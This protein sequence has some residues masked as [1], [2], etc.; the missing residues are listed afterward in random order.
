MDRLRQIAERSLRAN[1]VQTL[2]GPALRAGGHQH[3]TL[4]TRDFCYAVPGLIVIKEF[5]VVRNH[6][7]LLLQA[8]R[9]DGRVPRLMDEYPSLLRTLRW[10]LIRKVLPRHRPAKI[11][12]GR[13]HYEFGNELSGEFSRDS[14]G[15]PMDVGV[16]LYLATVTASEPASA[17]DI[18]L[19]EPELAVLKRIFKFYERAS[20]NFSRAIAQ[21]AFS[22]W[23][24]SARRRGRVDYVNYLCLRMLKDAVKRQWASAEA[25]E[26][27][28]AVFH[29]EFQWGVRDPERNLHS[30]RK[31]ERQIS[32]ETHLFRIQDLMNDGKVESARA[33]WRALK[34]HPLFHRSATA[35][36]PVDPETSTD[37][38]SLF[39]KALGLRHYHDRMVWTWLVGESIKTAAQVG[40]REV[41]GEI[42]QRFQE[43]CVSEGEVP[44]VLEAESYA[45]FA[46]LLYESERPFSWGA[47]KIL[48]GLAAVSSMRADR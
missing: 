35:G 7:R 26:K 36:V 48:E 44:E 13:L 46:N 1:I 40:D 27:F 17:S 15:F 8:V 3:S 21:G 14:G 11:W 34:D 29:N 41:A 42:I 24:E 19:E 33:L 37:D 9:P 30:V 10:T 6:L 25:L 18:L 31:S 4:R 38:I 45:S 23:Q 5:E 2:E 28:T 16:L 12:K 32:L 47:A 22:D 39:A 20:D 43:V